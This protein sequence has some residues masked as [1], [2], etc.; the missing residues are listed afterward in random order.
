MRVFVLTHTQRKL[1]EHKVCFVN[2]PTRQRFCSFRVN[3]LVTSHSPLLFSQRQHKAQK[4]VSLNTYALKEKFADHTCTEC[5]VFALNKLIQHEIYFGSNEV[6]RQLFP[7][8]QLFAPFQNKELNL[9]GS[10]KEGQ[11][12]TSYSPLT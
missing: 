10:N 9:K 7:F 3:S 12:A 6:N 8:L 4:N 5:I 11:S 2:K 1:K